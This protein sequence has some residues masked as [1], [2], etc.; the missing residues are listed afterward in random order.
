MPSLS[1]CVC[2]AEMAPH[3]GARL[4]LSRLP[5]KFQVRGWIALERGLILVQIA[6]QG[7]ASCPRL[8]LSDY[9]K[10]TA[11][12]LHSDV[13]LGCHPLLYS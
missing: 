6:H 2:G 11:D 9:L 4:L 8:K 10:F 13:F 3:C 1:V 7:A 5:I 12:L